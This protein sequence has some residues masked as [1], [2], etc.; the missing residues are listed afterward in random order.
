MVALKRSAALTLAL[1][2][3]AVGGKARQAGQAQADG[4]T[5][6]PSKLTTGKLI[7]VA[8]MP[9]DLD[10][11]IMEDL[12]AWGKYKVTS[13]PEGVDL[14]VRVNLPEKDTRYVLRGGIPRPAKEPKKPPAPSI[15]VV[16]WVTGQHLWD[17]DLLDKRPT[18]V[19]SE[20]PA[21]PHAQINAHGL[22]PD[23]LGMKITR[24]FRDY[25]EG[26]EKAESRRQ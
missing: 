25:V 17:A 2:A 9:E 11:W 18:Q 19:E 14:V 22:K 6:R 7:Y 16:D 1:I 21:G 20:P 15:E 13:N 10:R 23:Q 24:Q 8:S 26:L 12:H 4:S 3:L 5:P